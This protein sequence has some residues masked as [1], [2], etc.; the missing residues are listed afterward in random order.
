MKTI[1]ILIF[2]ILA[3]QISVSNAAPVKGSGKY[4]RTK[5]EM[6]PETTDR[7]LAR[8]LINEQFSNIIGTS[9]KNNIGNAA[10]LDLSNSPKATFA[11]SA[12]FRNGSILGFTVDGGINDGIMPIF[13]NSKLNTNVSLSVRYNIMGG[14][15]KNLLKNA[16]IYTNGLNAYN[17]KLD[18]IDMQYWIDSLSIRYNQDLATLEI[19]IDKAEFQKGTIETLLIKSANTVKVKDSLTFA[20]ERLS[21]TIQY[22]KKKHDEAAGNRNVLMLGLHDRRVQSESDL[23]VSCEFYRFHLQWFTLGYKVRNNSFRLFDPSLPYDNQVTSTN[24]V[25]HEFSGMWSYYSWTKR[26]YRTFF[27]S[28]GADL[29]YSDNLADLSTVEISEVKNYGTNPN[30]RSTTKKYNAYTGEYTK[31]LLGLKLSADF[32][33]FLFNNN[34]GA[35]HVFPEF[36]TQPKQPP[37]LSEGIGFMF[38]FHQDKNPASLINV[39]VFYKFIDNFNTLSST[40]GFFERNLIG[41]NFSVPIQFK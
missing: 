24:F 35:V 10:S 15:I 30:D 34:L 7:L 13:T 17:R 32:Y 14:S 1:F 37:I 20:K 5:K 18:S 16:A 27:F 33:Y 4:P 28:A 40:K 41:L 25:S 38:A 29:T 39:E 3:M 11:G 31:D 8:K 22:L 9:A 23:K 26:S 19:Q 6:K 12:I 21:V 36:I 2:L